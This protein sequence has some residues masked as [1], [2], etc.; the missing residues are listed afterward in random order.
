VGWFG[1]GGSG[2]L[3]WGLGFSGGWGFGVQS[4]VQGLG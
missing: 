1:G 2:V 3:G 4:R